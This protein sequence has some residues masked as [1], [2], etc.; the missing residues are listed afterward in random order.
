MNNTYFAYAR[1]STAGQSDSSISVQLAYLKIKADD[2]HLEFKPFHEKMSGSSITPRIELN[3]IIAHAKKGDYIG[4]YDSSRLG[5]NTPESLALVSDFIKRGIKVQ[6]GGRVLDES[7]PRDELIFTIESAIAQFQLKEQKLKS[8]IGIDEK[9]KNGE[10]LF[11]GRLLGYDLEKDGNKLIA[12]INEDEAAIIRYIF[13]EYA[14]G[15]SINKITND[16]VAK[17]YRTKD[18]DQFVAATVRR[19]IHKPI[20]KGFYK[21]EKCAK[22]VGQDKLSLKDSSLIKSKYY[23]PIVSEELWDRVNYSYRHVRRAHSIQFPYKYAQFELS[24]IIKCYYCKKLGKATGYVHSYHKPIDS[25]TVNSNYINRVHLEG[26]EQTK[27]T[28]RASVFESLFRLCYYLVFAEENELNDFLVQQKEQAEAGNKE[29]AADIQRLDESIRELEKKENNIIRAVV[30]FGMEDDRLVK[31]LDKLKKE[32]K[33][34]KEERDLKAIGISDSEELFMKF[35]EEYSENSLISF[36]REETPSARRSHYIRLL[37]HA[38]VYKERLTV[39]FKNSKVFVIQL[40][41]N[42]GR[43]I[44][45]IFQVKVGYKGREQYIATIDTD[46]EEISLC[47]VKDRFKVQS[48]RNELFKEAKRLGTERAIVSLLDRIK[49][50]RS[51]A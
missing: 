34:L 26:C 10:W 4:V 25:E 2:L 22:G 11:T 50:Y 5:R 8:L 37:D 32:E 13:E 46:T 39:L 33:Q 49:I 43:K 14:K 30:T 27:Q 29:V 24:S 36:I 12:K 16:L 9:R 40:L 17:G 45:R 21:T 18:G 38:Y 3:Y 48:E 19:Y 20:Y 35:R 41:P 7:S 28:F 47:L 23:L 51:H 31:E 6:I 44:Q 15:K 42:K 1:V